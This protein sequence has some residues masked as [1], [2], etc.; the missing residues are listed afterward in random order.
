M[1]LRLETVNFTELSY[2]LFRRQF[3][4]W[5]RLTRVVE[6]CFELLHVCLRV[7]TVDLH[8]SSWDEDNTW[9]AKGSVKTNWAQIGVV[10]PYYKCKH[11]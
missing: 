1:N 6:I 10:L 11:E 7:Y 9:V 8:V 5:R 4:N 3:A 2:V